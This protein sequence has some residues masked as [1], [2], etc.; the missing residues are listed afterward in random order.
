[1]KNG[2]DISSKGPRVGAVIVT[3]NRQVNL[4]RTL[5]AVMTQTFAPI[6]AYVVDNGSGGGTANL[7]R[8]RGPTVRYVPMP[9]NL[10]YAAGLARGMEQSIDQGFEYIWLLDDDSTPAP[11][12]LRR[13]LEVAT[14]LPTCAIVGLSGGELRRGVPL[15]H[16]TP[17]PVSSL[18]GQPNVFRSDFVLVD[19]ALVSAEA[20]RRVG[21][22]RADFF[23]MME[24][25]EYSA[26][27][28]RAGWDV[29][30]LSEPL[31][32]RGHLGSGGAGG[33]SPP[34]RGYYQTRNHLRVALEHRSAIEVWGW[35]VRQL[36]LLVGAAV[37]ADR[38]WERIRLRLLGAWHGLRGVSGRT[39]DPSVFP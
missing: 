28:R 12:A 1:M 13:C 8:E 39:V 32:E 7:A 3:F 5:D 25:V 27:M 35:L 38:R 9:E 24:D 29:V 17:L 6:V 16:P 36:K 21:Y 11:D 22:P 26:R 30:V 23:M 31:I 34:W 18:Q 2:S 37:T 33:A 4:L 19:G 14:A 10:G 20:V 15:H